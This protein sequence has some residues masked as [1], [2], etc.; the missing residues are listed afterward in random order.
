MSTLNTLK[1]GVVAAS[2]GAAV[3][4]APVA[5]SAARSKVSSASNS[6]QSNPNA[7]PVPVKHNSNQSS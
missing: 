7:N 5:A 4:L 3:L 2:I 1:K 6:K